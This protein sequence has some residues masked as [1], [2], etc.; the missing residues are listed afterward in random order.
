MTT[1]S[2]HQ[3]RPRP[4]KHIGRRRPLLAALIAAGLVALGANAD[5]GVIRM[6]EARFKDRC[7]VCHGLDAKGAAPFAAMLVTEPADLTV[8][9]ETNGGVF[10]FGRVYD[11]IDGRDMVRAHGVRSMPVWGREWAESDA[12]GAETLIRGKILEIIIYLRSIQR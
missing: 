7:A 6:G 11:A 5:E 4:Q 8:L 12:P 2:L 1:P 3:R 9:A 10:P